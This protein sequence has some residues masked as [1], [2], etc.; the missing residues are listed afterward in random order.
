MK[1]NTVAHIM[2]GLSVLLTEKIMRILRLTR[3][4]CYLDYLQSFI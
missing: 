1:I 2:S 4:A 3:V